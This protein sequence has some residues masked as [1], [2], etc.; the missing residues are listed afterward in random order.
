MNLKHMLLLLVAAAPGVALGA[1]PN[2]PS[3]TVLPTLTFSPSPLVVVPK[4]KTPVQIIANPASQGGVTYKFTIKEPAVKGLNS[5]IHTTS[6]LTSYKSDSGMLGDDKFTVRL[7]IQKNGETCKIGGDKAMAYLTVPV[8]IDVPTP[9]GPPEVTGGTASRGNSVGNV[10]AEGAVVIDNT[11][12]PGTPGIMS[13]LETKVG[14]ARYLNNT[15]HISFNGL[16][17]MQRQGDNDLWD[18]IGTENSASVADSQFGTAKQSKY[19]VDGQSVIDL[20]RLRTAADWL[21]AN[22]APTAA[23]PAGTYGTISWM[24]FVRNAALDIPMYG[25]VRVMVPLKLKSGKKSD[26]SYHSGDSNNDGWKDDDENHDGYSDGD[27]DRNG[28]DDHDNDGD[29]H[30]DNEIDD[31]LNALKVNTPSNRIYAFCTQDEHDDDHGD[32]DGDGHDDSEESDHP[33]S[34]DGDGHDSEGHDSTPAPL[35]G[36]SNAPIAGIEF[37]YP[38]PPKVYTANGYTFTNSSRIRVYGTLFMDFVSAEP[39]AVNPVAG[40]PLLPENLPFHPRDILIE[41][42][43]PFLINPALDA[44]ADDIMDNLEYIDGISKNVSCTATPCTYKYP[45]PQSWDF[46]RVDQSM[47][48]RFHFQTGVT[49]TQTFY[50][51]LN[52]ASKYHLLMPTGYEA[53]WNHAFTTLGVNATQ[54][55]DLGFGVPAEAATAGRILTKGDILSSYWEDVPAYISTGG[56]FSMRGHVNMSGLL[57]I[58]QAIE[59]MQTYFNSARQYIMGGVIVRDGFYIEGIHADPTLRGIS[60]ITS[61]PNAFAQVKINPASVQTSNTFKTANTTIALGDP[62]PVTAS[63]ANTG[64]ADTCAGCSGTTGAVIPQTKGNT[65]VIVR[66]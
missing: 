6:G 58:P 2:C 44:N 62:S 24:E 40:T 20:N 39:D 13:N 11:P 38:E 36:C 27:H 14:G 16:Q 8:V 66:P 25:V 48:D 33:R 7:S 55:K 61:D 64:G 10:A 54:W 41:T 50:D 32:S 49:L 42:A 34:H 35:T 65:F 17:I 46:A 23:R 37:E 4:V 51:N 29:G 57:Y 45:N 3:G 28:H 43:I 31:E 47:K 60:V 18:E 59:L 5:S 22:V 30:D 53:G 63:G 52:T 15:N 21:R 26:G 19:F 9:H 1:T 56:L 12:N